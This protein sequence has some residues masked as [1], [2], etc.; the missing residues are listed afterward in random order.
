ML[1]LAQA[2]ELPTEAEAAIDTAGDDMFANL[3]R[4]LQ[5]AKVKK[6]TAYFA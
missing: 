1:D 2:P 6:L 3:H 5:A 4:D